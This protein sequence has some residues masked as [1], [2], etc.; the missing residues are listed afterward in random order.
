[1]SKV[2]FYPIGN[3]VL[4]EKPELKEVKT[5]SGL[6]MPQNTEQ[7]REALTVSKIIALGD[8]IKS[9]NLKVGTTIKFTNPHEISH[10]GKEYFLI[11]ESNVQLILKQA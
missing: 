7:S 3:R 6:Y 4:V 9:K 11:H 8:D 5:S 2:D 10:N 1:M